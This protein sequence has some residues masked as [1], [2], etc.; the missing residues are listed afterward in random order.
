MSAE[1][2]ERTLFKAVSASA[3]LVFTQDKHPKLANYVVL[4][5]C[6][7]YLPSEIQYKQRVYSSYKIT[8]AK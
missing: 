6:S 2:E 4:H 1:W 7:S 8:V 3:K 5:I